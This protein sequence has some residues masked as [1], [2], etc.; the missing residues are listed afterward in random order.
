MKFKEPT[1]GIGMRTL[2]RKRGY[3]VYLVDEFRTSR[4]CSNCNGGICE[5]FN[6]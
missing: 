1:I 3:Q 6:V 4:R 2:F 5:K